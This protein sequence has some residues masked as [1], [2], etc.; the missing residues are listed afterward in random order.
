MEQHTSD[1]A[2]VSEKKK[3]N[4]INHHNNRGIAIYIKYN[5]EYLARALSITGETLAIQI[6]Q[7]TIGGYNISPGIPI[8]NRDFQ[9]I[10]NLGNKFILIGDFN[11]KHRY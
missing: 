11:A 3:I 4:A 6:N 5:W 10:F 1:L 2:L 9:Q 8:P 7:I